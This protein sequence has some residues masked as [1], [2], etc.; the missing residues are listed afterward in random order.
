MP[1]LTTLALGWAML[2]PQSAPDMLEA[3]LRAHVRF[4]SHDLLEGRDSPSPGLTLAAEYIAG[5]FAKVGVRPGVEESFF[6][7]FE[8]T[9]RR[10]TVTGQVHNVI[11]VIP[12]R[13]PVL[14]NE[15]VFVTAHYDHLGKREGEGDQTFNGAN[16]NGSGTAGVIEVGRLLAA[17]PPK[18]TIV[19]MTFWGEEQGLLG[20]RAYTRTPV[21][22]LAKTVAMVNLEQ[23]GRTDD[24][25]GPRVG[26]FNLT[27]FD[28]SDLPQRIKEA[29][30]P[31]G[32]KVTKHPRFSDSYFGA[33][34]NA[35]F[36]S[37]GVPAHTISVAYAFP[38]YHKPG[39][40][41]SKLDYSNMSK[42]VAAIAKG[43]RSVADD[44]RTIRWRESERTKRY[45]EAWQKLT[46]GE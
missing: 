3:R 33:S 38:E 20:A 44:S 30:E 19:L 17:E 4:L 14:K 1:M 41:W 27:G 28:F 12:G 43:V 29:V 15:F 39:D 26:E 7:S 35:A 11:G 45:L 34:D 18:R 2:A 37:L 32:V 40:E 16:D 6:Q 8:H 13:D 42:L 31:T 9:R 10:G 23:I 46:G 25:E 5:E 21:F 22:P 36:A 24:N